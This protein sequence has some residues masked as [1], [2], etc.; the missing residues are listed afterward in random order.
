M[1]GKLSRRTL[2]AGLGAA[3]GGVLGSAGLV[4]SHYLHSGDGLS[5]NHP[6]IST[7]AERDSA[8]A[9]VHP[10]FYCDEGQELRDYA[11]EL[12]H[13]DETII[14]LVR[15]AY[16][17]G[18][19]L[20]ALKDHKQELFEIDEPVLEKFIKDVAR[21]AAAVK[22]V[23][24]ADKINYGVFGDITSHVHMHI[25]PKHR[26]GRHWGCAFLSDPP[27]EIPY[28]PGEFERVKQQLIDEL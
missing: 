12:I 24:K 18:R 4:I 6:S 11:E 5:M 15:N 28:P 19:C 23:F 22:K 3:A 16:Y 17:K 1:N 9:K 2:I 25:V 10:C 13:Y 14:Y 21:V 27:E 20:V 26:D 7:T 8:M